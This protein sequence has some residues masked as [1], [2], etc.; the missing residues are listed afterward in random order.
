MRKMNIMILILSFLSCVFIDSTCKKDKDKHDL[1]MFTNNSNK[2]IFVKGSWD[3]PDTTI[4]FSNLALAGNF[5]KVS[6]NSSDDP[7]RIKDTY[8]G[9]FEQCEKLIVFVFDSQVLEST[10]W[11]TIKVKYLILMRYDLSLAD[12]QKLNWTITYP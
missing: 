12:L 7:L 3:Y 5:Y 6:A 1:I 9:R 10:P 2:I 11:D 4:N 8:E